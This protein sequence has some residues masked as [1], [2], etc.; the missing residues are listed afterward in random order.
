MDRKYDLRNESSNSFNSTTILNR[1]A[2]GDKQAVKECIDRYGNL[3]WNIARKYQSNTADA[4]DAVQEI[5]IDIWKMPP[6]LILRNLLK[7]HS[8]PLLPAGE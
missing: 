3:V 7:K 5:F 4:E 1:I 8:L 6:D 2:D